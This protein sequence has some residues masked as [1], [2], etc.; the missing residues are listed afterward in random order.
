M[1]LYP[2]SAIA[3]RYFSVPLIADYYYSESGSSSDSDDSMPELEESSDDGSS[4]LSGKRTVELV[5]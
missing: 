3:M 1:V 2:R 4:D 5:D